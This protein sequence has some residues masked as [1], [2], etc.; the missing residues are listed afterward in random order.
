METRE[1]ILNELK[2]I[3]PTL[4]SVPKVNLY[5]V[6]EGYFDAF[7]ANFFQQININ[8]VN[9]ELS[10]VAPV[11]AKAGKKEQV[12]VPT[13]YFKSFPLELLNKIRAEEAASEL[14]A[15]APMLSGL[16]KP[17]LPEVPSNYFALFPTQ[18]VRQI[19]V[20][21]KP[22][23]TTDMPQWLSAIN[24]SIERVTT[25]IF[26]PKYSFAFAATASV[27]IVSAVLMLKVQQNCADIDCKMAQLS[28]QEL[29]TYLQETEYLNS[30][31]VFE[32]SPAI[33]NLPA[34]NGS[35]MKAAFS[36]ISDEELYNAILD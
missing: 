28:D 17:A 12:E 1:K 9:A 18:M 36:N 13:G 21:Q 27:I 2:E 6:P 4:A 23:Q 7:A 29:N 33:E 22:T 34:D 26:K 30:P 15:V 16:Q 14:Q 5:T 3:A 19:A 11:L 24:R 25:T 35:P 8:E 31:E 10:N 32:L 20:A